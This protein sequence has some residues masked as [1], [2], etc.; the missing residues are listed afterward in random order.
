MS[1]LAAALDDDSNLLRSFKALKEK[2]IEDHHQ[3]ILANA[4]SDGKF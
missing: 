1:R 4:V 3:G 2:D